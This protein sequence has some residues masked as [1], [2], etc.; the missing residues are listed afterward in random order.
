MCGIVGVYSRNGPVSR[1]ALTRATTAL[2]HRGPDDENVWIS[3]AGRVGLGHT[4]LSIVDLASRAH[5]LSSEDG[6]VRLVV[7][8]EFYGDAEIRR[9]LERRGHRFRT[10]SDSEVALHLY[11]E[12]GTDCLRHLRGEF[13][14]ILW[15]DRRAQLFAA[16]DRF[17]IKPLF[18]AEHGG[19][20]FLASEGKALLAAGLPA[21]WDEETVYDY[22]FFCMDRRRS[23]FR[24]IRQVPPG[25]FLLAT[26][27]SSRL[28]RYWDITF[29]WARRGPRGLRGDEL[30]ERTR[31]LLEEAVRLRLRG[32][33]P[34]GVLLSGGLDSSSV[35]G[36]AAAH[37]G[38]PLTV[39]TLAFE[40]DG[41]DERE[42]A[43]R[44]ARHVGARFNPLPVG[45]AALAETF[46]D[47]VLHGETV[48]LNGHAS[49][50]FLLSRLVQR[51]GYKV[52][53]SGEGGDELFAG[54][55]FCQPPSSD[56]PNRGESLFRR[57]LRS[58]GSADRPEQVTAE[59]SPWLYRLSR[60]AA[61][62]AP[63]RHA[64]ADGLAMIRSVIAAEFLEKF[65]RRDP[66]GDL[67]LGLDLRRVVGREPARQLL[68][69]WTK[70]FFVNYHLAADRLDMAHGV[71]VRL[72]F[73]DHVLFDAVS[74]LPVSLLRMGDRPKGLL[75]AAVEPFVP[76]A[77]S[78]RP[79]HGF[80]APPLSLGEQGRTLA[81]IQDAVRAPSFRSVPF[82]D[83]AGVLAL[84][85]RVPRLDP[86]RR[87]LADPLV[88][89]VGSFAILH[90]RYRL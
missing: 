3:P 48:Q 78:R 11:E 60:L 87:R 1:V 67:L 20:L 38:H 6:A 30:V 64:L 33:V 8:G 73:L 88:L 12:L 53:L 28:V 29:P 37:A 27:R 9:D 57:L 39:F 68:Y 86:Q 15:D 75:R 32:D 56:A 69:V 84:L 35:L 65:R 45:E 82:L 74:A 81:L 44:M 26:A 41:F 19:T 46:V 85:D 43:A 21:A 24:G 76:P 4:R 62:S 34:A 42:P 66:Y 14:F 55:G 72:P 13:A 52:V 40:G 63:S 58:F 18:Y 7:N 71:E 70:S 49:A 10:R 31:H 47:T 79:K 50:R 23:L 90:D 22:L 5:P 89:M 25:E 59:I 17:G 80:L 36:L 77:I 61:V 54:Y 51:S 2:R 83:P 16:R